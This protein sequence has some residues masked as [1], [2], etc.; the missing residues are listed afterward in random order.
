MRG[1]NIRAFKTDSQTRKYLA[2]LESNKL[3]KNFL[4]HAYH[5]G[6]YLNQILDDGD[7][8]NHSDQ[9]TTQTQFPGKKDQLSSFALRDLKRGEELCEH[10]GEYGHPEWLMKLCKEFKCDEGYYT[11]KD[12]KATK[13]S[14]KAKEVKP[15]EEISGFQV[16]YKVGDASFGKGLIA[17]QDIPKG[18]LVW[19]CKPGVNVRQLKGDK[20]TRKHL[21]TLKTV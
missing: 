19:K 6:G 2:T 11:I 1:Q 15:K 3:R 8:F 13:K 18:T 14:K 17:D 7:C 4:D 21:A 10:Y 5:S 16:K 12:M 20:A 9:P